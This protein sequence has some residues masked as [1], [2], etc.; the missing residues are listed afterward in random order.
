MLAERQAFCVHVDPDLED[1]LKLLLRGA[2]SVAEYWARARAQQQWQDR[3]GDP[4]RRQSGLPP[5][6]PW[7]GDGSGGTWTDNRRRSK[8]QRSE[9]RFRDGWQ[10]LVVVA[11][12]L[13]GDIG[14]CRRP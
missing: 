13:P 10:I 4:W 2:I 9:R 12:I 14:F 1:L 8:G 3:A 5:F 11:F 7:Q 6:D